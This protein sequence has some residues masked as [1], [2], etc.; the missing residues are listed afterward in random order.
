MKIILRRRAFSN[1][2]SSYLWTALR[3]LQP[4][5][6]ATTS[7]AWALDLEILRI[8]VSTHAYTSSDYPKFEV[9]DIGL[10]RTDPR[11]VCF[12]ELY[13]GL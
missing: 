12:M 3:I 6:V 7:L 8:A 11:N 13:T 10:R 5:L 4:G 1:V 2:R 9:G